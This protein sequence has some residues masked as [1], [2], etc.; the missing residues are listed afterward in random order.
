M[1]TLETILFNA[2]NIV[3]VYLRD[4]GDE[5]THAEVT[6]EQAPDL[7]VNKEQH[8]KYKEKVKEGREVSD[9]LLDFMERVGDTFLIWKDTEGVL[10]QELIDLQ[11][12]LDEEKQDLDKEPNIAKIAKDNIKD[13]QIKIAKV[14]QSLKLVKFTIE[15]LEPS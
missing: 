10:E 11:N 3:D 7:D 15:S 13:L 5:L 9:F 12:M 14:N 2:I 4:M 8:A 1:S 6:L